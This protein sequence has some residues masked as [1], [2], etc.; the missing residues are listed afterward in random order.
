MTDTKKALLSQHDTSG[1]DAIAEFIGPEDIMAATMEWGFENLSDDDLIQLEGK[2]SSL[3]DDYT[4]NYA[5][6]DDWDDSTIKT[7]MGLRALEDAYRYEY[8]KRR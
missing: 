8:D 6:S 7:V 3:V 4:I 1:Y 5:S 2:M